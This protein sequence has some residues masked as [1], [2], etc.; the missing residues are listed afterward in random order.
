MFYASLG[1]KKNFTKI[2]VILF[3]NT[4][5]LNEG[6]KMSHTKLTGLRCVPLEYLDQLTRFVRGRIFSV[7]LAHVFLMF[8]NP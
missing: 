5:K 7:G 6:K 2:L 8:S 3:L 4:Q 1:L